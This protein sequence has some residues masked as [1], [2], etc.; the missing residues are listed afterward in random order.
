[1]KS[2]LRRDYFYM[3]K[4]EIVDKIILIDEIVA[5]GHTK[6]TVTEILDL[7]L[8]EIQTA[9]VDG[10]KVSISGFG[11]FD[12]RERKERVGQNPATG[13]KM[14]IPASKNVKFTPSSALK[15]AVNE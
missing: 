6:K 10:E 8:T 13:E 3:T 12:V 1:M 7:F 14:T 5:Q 4:K 15:A 9:L 11:N 2:N